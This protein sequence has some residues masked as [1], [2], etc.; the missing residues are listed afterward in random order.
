M[1]YPELA[2][3]SRIGR[4]L[5]T[6]GGTDLSRSPTSVA[7]WLRALLIVTVV[8]FAGA[9]AVELY[10]ATHYPRE[11]TVDFLYDD[12]YYYLGVADSLAHGAG[13]KFREPLETNGYQ[14]LWLGMLAG[15]ARLLQLSKQGLF[16]ATIALTYALKLGVLLLYACARTRSRALLGVGT[17][18][19]I[20]WTPHV[21]SLGL[22]TTLLLLAIP[23]LPWLLLP[24]AQSASSALARGALFA[25][26]FLV[27]LDCAALFA[28]HA[29]LRL[30]LDRRLDRA[31]FLQGAVLA[32]VAAGYFALNYAWFGVPVPVSGLAKSLGSVPGENLAVPREYIPYART[33]LSF[34]LAPELLR[35]LLPPAER[36]RDELFRRTTA[37]LGLTALLVVAYYTFLSGWPIWAWYVWPFSLLL[38]F[39]FAR[40]VDLLLALSDARAVSS[41]W[42]W[43]ALAVLGVVLLF[44]GR[45]ARQFFA[46]SGYEQI[47]AVVKHELPQLS[48]RVPVQRSFNKDNVQLLETFFAARPEGGRVVMGD[49]AGALGYWLPERYSFVHSEGLVGSYA[50]LRARTEERGH[51]FLDALKP[52]Y[53]VVDRD[54]LMTEQTPAGAV[55][56]VPE[57]I[58]G[59]SMHRGVMLFCF[60][61]D[62]V[63]H[64]AELPIGPIHWVRPRYVFDYRKQRSCS[65]ALTQKLEALLAEPVALRRF[66]M[67]SEYGF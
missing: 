52:D 49:R 12:A 4:P 21:F 2:S 17:V 22:E 9:A 23:C 5:A 10:A 36:A 27:R 31:L 15:L 48:A 24:S 13:S 43:L 16:V 51:A 59:V 39:S 61:E 45:I 42:R 63:L 58:Q 67:F 32:S 65:P 33:A 28:S 53:L 38:A 50:F 37:V 18:L 57:P 66:S 41:L 62:A 35:W 40:L 47:A 6:E 55:L 46:A 54:R 19:A 64:H 26:L 11:D 7:P 56:G 3:P 20:A 8:A 29:V 60:G 44:S 25:L 1:R 14:P 30:A 34:A